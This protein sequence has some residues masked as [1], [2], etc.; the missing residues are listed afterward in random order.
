GGESLHAPIADPA[1]ELLDDDPSLAAGAVVGTYTI[2]RE[3][4]RGGMGRVYLATDGRLG[5][6]VALKALAPHLV[7]DP[8][9]RERL[10]REAR[11]AAGLT[12][13]GVCTGDAPGEL[14]GGVH[15]ATGYVGGETPG[16]G[17]RPGTAAAARRCRPDGARS[18]WRA[19]L[20]TCRRHRAPR[21]EARQRHARARWPAQDPGFRPGAI[22]EHRSPS[23]CVVRDAARGPDGH[24]GI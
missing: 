7:R 15:I 4:G 14:D 10:R 12:P 3:L 24:A 2:V 19:G 6:T 16:R 9:Q 23:G 20:C 8:L 13:P 1:P 11:A 5:R 22:A 17:K 21:S 18:G